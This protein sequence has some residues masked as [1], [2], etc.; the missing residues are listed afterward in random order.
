LVADLLDFAR[1][2]D[3]YLFSDECYDEIVFEGR[4]VSPASLLTPHEFNEGRVTCIYTFSKSYAMT[5][6]RIGYIVTGAELL[7]TISNVLDASYTNISTAIQ[8]AAAAALSGPQDCVGEMRHAYRR[9]RDLAVSLLK[10]HGRY[11]YTPRG[12]FYI[13]IDIT[14]AQHPQRHARQFTLDL[15]RETNITVAPGSL[16]GPA[17]DHYVRVS[18]AASDEEIER[19]MREIC[20]F[21]DK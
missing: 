4:H 1:R 17:A 9:R 16:F 14:N 3:L 13:L 21:A 12:A 19:G 11:V 6:W 8:R 2:H 7:K 15:L 10:D 20:R 18:L 5:G